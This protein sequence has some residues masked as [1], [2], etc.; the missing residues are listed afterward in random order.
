[1]LWHVEVDSE[2]HGTIKLISTPNTIVYHQGSS[3][4]VTDINGEL[5][6]DLPLRGEYTLTVNGVDYKVYMPKGMSRDRYRS[7]GSIPNGPGRVI[8]SLKAVPYG[9]DSSMLVLVERVLTTNRTGG[10]VTKASGFTVNVA[11]GIAGVSFGGSSLV[12]PADSISLVSVTTS[13]VLEVSEVLSS[14]VYQNTPLAIITSTSL[15]VGSVTNL[16]SETS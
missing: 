11:S 15:E 9:L 14:K 3:L 13:G 5:S 2:N 6:L 1:M 7:T 12:I 16:P 8:R 10:Q 4:G